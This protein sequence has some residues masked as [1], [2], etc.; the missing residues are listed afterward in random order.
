M[1]LHRFVLHLSE[2]TK[3]SN[4]CRWVTLTYAVLHLS[5]LTKLSNTEA[6]EIAVTAFYIFLN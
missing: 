3:L 4:R 5:E 6:T 1:I 2:L